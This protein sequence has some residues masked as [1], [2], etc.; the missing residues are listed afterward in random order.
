MKTIINRFQERARRVS[1]REAVGLVE[2]GL[3]APP[4][5]DGEVRDPADRW[6]YSTKSKWRAMRRDHLRN[7]RRQDLNAITT[8][9]RLARAAK[10]AE[11]G[12][13]ATP[14]FDHIRDTRPHEE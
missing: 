2:R 14:T 13:R 5:A 8:Q 7:A 9:N 6:H 4:L 11:H 3:G 1:D 12:A 10:K